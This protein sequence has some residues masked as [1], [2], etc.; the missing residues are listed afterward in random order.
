[1]NFDLS[2]EL[3]TVND[4]PIPKEFVVFFRDSS[5]PRVFLNV[6]NPLVW[7]KDLGVSEKMFAETIIMP[8]DAS[9]FTD[10]SECKDILKMRM[11]YPGVKDDPEKLAIAKTW[12]LPTKIHNGPVL[13]SLLTSESVTPF[14]DALNPYFETLKVANKK[15]GLLKVDIDSGLERRVVY[16][17]LDEGFRPSLMLIKWSNDVDTD[18]STANCA[19]HIHNCGYSLAK[20]ENGFYLYYFSDQVMYDIASWKT[21]GYQNP[22]MR[23]L[24]Q[25]IGESFAKPTVQDDTVSNSVSKLLSSMNTSS[26]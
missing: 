17:I 5:G 2:G 6:C 20:V 4:R 19:G 14:M 22:V 9:V 15:V 8:T 24:I 1:M 12:V 21:E 3:Q 13:S 18:Y 7:K 26:E 10:L 16:Q 25:Q 11:R 23:T